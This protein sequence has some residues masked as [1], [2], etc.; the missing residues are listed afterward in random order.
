MKSKLVVMLAG[1]ACL[2]ACV[3]QPDATP[4]AAQPEPT[5]PPAAA[6]P[7]PPASANW[8]DIA[9]T[10]GD[11]SYGREANGGT[12]ARFGAAETESLFIVRCEPSRQV[13]LSVEGRASGSMTLRTSFGARSLPLTLQA[14]P[15]AYSSAVVA[16]TDPLLDN[17]AFSRGRFTVEVPGARMLVLPAWA[18]V[19]R[20][21]ED[22]RS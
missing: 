15:I 9:L 7:P 21:V 18:E 5:P 10:P 11:W 6:P 14:Q 4:P 1:A 2:T 8:Q 19:A 20:I 17:I 3:P 12:A 22:C 13:R 16:A